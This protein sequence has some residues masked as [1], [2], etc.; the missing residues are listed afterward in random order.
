MTNSQMLLTPSVAPNTPAP[1]LN[2]CPVPN[3]GGAGDIAAHVLPAAEYDAASTAVPFALRRNA[4][5]TVW[6]TGTS[7]QSFESVVDSVE[8]TSRSPPPEV[9][10]FVHVPAV[11]DFWDR[12]FVMFGCA[13]AP[14]LYTASITSDASGAN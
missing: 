2:A 6:V 9:G 3:A 12:R 7:A 1:L 4:Y 14:L 10:M 13:S 5:T 11:P 8:K